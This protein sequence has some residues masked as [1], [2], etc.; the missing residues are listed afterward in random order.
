MSAKR[1]QRRRRVSAEPDWVTEALSD[2]LS[3]RQDLGK[4]PSELGRDASKTVV[5][6]VQRLELREVFP[7]LQQVDWRELLDDRRTFVDL[8]DSAQRIFIA[9]KYSSITGEEALKFLTQAFQKE[10]VSKKAR[11]EESETKHSQADEK[12]SEYWLSRVTNERKSLDAFEIFLQ[13]IL[14]DNSVLQRWWEK[15]KQRFE[16]A[17]NEILSYVAENIDQKIEQLFARYL[18]KDKKIAPISQRS[19]PV[20]M[21]AYMTIAE[22][23]HVHGENAVSFA[24]STLGFATPPEMDRLRSLVLK[25]DVKDKNY[26]G[27]SDKE[28]AYMLYPETVFAR[29]FAFHEAMHIA[30]DGITEKEEVETAGG[31]RL[32]EK[33]GF[34]LTYYYKDGQLDKLQTEEAHRQQPLQ[35]MDE[36]A[37]VLI[38]SYVRN[39]QDWYETMKNWKEGFNLSRSYFVAT[40]ATIEVVR[41]VG[42]DSLLSC[43]IKSDIEGWFRMINSKCE[44]SVLN[45]YLAV[46]KEAQRGFS[47]FDF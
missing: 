9:E 5:Q 39:N 33:R 19:Y 11:L 37:V 28:F 38:D 8:S 46:L 2:D 6:D 36:G 31:S 3:D 17:E 44:A 22:L 41:E 40:E 13:E 30:V 16:N 18:R 20:L 45:K 47:P 32:V 24:Y 14:D 25:V 10:L 43:Y 23:F 4:K 1:E 34:H 12:K 15:V 7:S 27:S 35:A 29:S 26:F 42:I 21:A